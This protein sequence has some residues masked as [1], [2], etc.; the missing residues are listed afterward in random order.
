MDSDEN[1]DS[2]GPSGF[3]FMS[4]SDNRDANATEDASVSGFGFMSP[5]TPVEDGSEGEREAPVSGFDFMSSSV[6]ESATVEE[7]ILAELDLENQPSL[8]S[9]QRLLSVSFLYSFRV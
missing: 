1:R 2:N 6:E 3:G 5:A 8:P 4:A 7:D 9:R